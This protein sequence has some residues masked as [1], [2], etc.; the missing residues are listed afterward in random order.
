VGAPTRETSRFRRRVL[1]GEFLAGRR[2]LRQPAVAAVEKGAVWMDAG[3]YSLW[4]EP[5][6]ADALGSRAA[7]RPPPQK[8]EPAEIGEDGLTASRENGATTGAALLRAASNERRQA[9]PLG[10]PAGL[11]PGRGGRLVAEVA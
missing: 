4:K 3:A 7:L 6:P 11:D 8:L 9:L 5:V 2:R 10:R 1:A